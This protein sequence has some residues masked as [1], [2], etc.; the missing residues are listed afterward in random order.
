MPTRKDSEGRWHVEVCVSRRRVHRRLSAG[1][2]ARDAKQLEA[3]LVRA[4]RQQTTARQPSVPG[5]PLLTD[6][7]A[8]YTERHAHHLRSPSTAQY[9]GYRIARWIDGKRA[10]DARTVA[11]GI[12]RDMRGAYAVGTINRSIGTLKR[13][14]TM[15]WEQGSTPVDYGAQIKRLPENNQRTTYLSVEQVKRLADHAS[16]AVRAAIWIALFT[17]CRRGEIAKIKREHVGEHAI[18]LPAGN[19]KTLRYREVPIAPALRPWLRFLP[20]SISARG[21]ESGFR[22]ARDAAGMPAVRFHDLRHSCATILLSSGTDLY[23]IAKILGHSSV[24]V[25]ERYAHAQIEAQQAA[26]DRAFSHPAFTPGD[27]KSA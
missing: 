1:A 20:L 4:L 12:V 10:S 17:G 5:D 2:T 11:A 15:A 6:L 22:N 26:L 14:L 23:T 7:M 9:H 13:A 25:T 8:E 21:I 16:E 18:R 19:T 3:E 27:R 24:K